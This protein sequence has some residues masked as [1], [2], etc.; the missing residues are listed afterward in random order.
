MSSFPP[1]PLPSYLLLLLA[2]SLPALFYLFLLFLI[3]ELTGA[4]SWLWKPL[5][6]EKYWFE[7][8]VELLTPG[9]GPHLL[10]RLT[11]GGTL[12]RWTFYTVNKLSPSS[13]G[14]FESQLRSAHYCTEK[15]NL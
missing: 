14:S 11:C 8:V 5:P 1:L 12:L 15:G 7:K 10:R 9:R 3:L 4:Y 2:L 13:L 6:T